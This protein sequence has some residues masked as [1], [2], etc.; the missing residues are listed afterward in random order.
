M[1]VE[2]LARDG[3]G[4]SD[5][6]QVGNPCRVGAAPVEPDASGAET[7]WKSRGAGSC[8]T[9]GLPADSHTQGLRALTEAVSNL[10]T[11]ACSVPRW[12]SL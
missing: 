3:Q 5:H 12:G 1:R 2:K 4:P 7:P 6:K 8:V 9:G 10:Q 11:S